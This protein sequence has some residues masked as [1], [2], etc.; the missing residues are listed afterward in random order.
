MH[1]HFCRENR[2]RRKRKK[3]LDFPQPLQNFFSEGFPS[4]FPLNLRSTPQHKLAVRCKSGST[5]V[6]VRPLD[7]ALSPKLCKPSLE[8]NTADASNWKT[9]KIPNGKVSY[10][11]MEETH[12]SLSSILTQKRRRV[13][14]RVKI[15][16]DAVCQTPETVSLQAEL[17]LQPFPRF[18][19]SIFVDV[20][21]FSHFKLLEIALFL[22]TF[23]A[24]K[25][26]QIPVA[27][28]VVALQ[29]TKLLFKCVEHTLY[30]FWLPH[31]RK[32]GGKEIIF[33]LVQRV[34]SVA[35]NCRQ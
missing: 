34:Q 5:F 28:F 14:L 25:L 19:V 3:C 13:E 6:C 12:K 17:T 10:R 21:F 8:R 20:T 32:L 18:N 22:L 29:G 33:S 16:S 23:N 26:R 11:I 7:A 27:R 9:L 31:R 30:Y 15:W 2:N 4:L 1:L 24:L 35:K